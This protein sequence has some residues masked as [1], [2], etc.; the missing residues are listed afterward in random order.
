MK[1]K[2]NI[3]VLAGGIAMLVLFSAAAFLLFRGISQYSTA[4]RKAD[5]LFKRLEKYYT[6]N[7]FPTPANVEVVE[8]NAAKL[9][10]WDALLVREMRKGEVVADEKSPSRF[11]IR[12]SN[13]RNALLGEAPR[14]SVVVRPGF[15]FGFEQYLQDGAQL[16]P[17]EIVQDLTRQLAIVDVI[18]KVLFTNQIAQLDLVVRED[19]QAL[20]TANA[21]PAA[22]PAG[23]ADPQP[24]PPAS[25][26]RKFTF[27]I[28]F[29]ATE[30]AALSVLNGLACEKTFIVPTSVKFVR[31]LPDIKEK[32][33]EADR[34]RELAARSTRGEG[35][36]EVP[37]PAPKPVSAEVPTRDERVVSGL[38][39]EQPM[40]VRIEMDVYGLRG[41]A[42]GE[43]V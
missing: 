21:T 41:E 8:R 4:G 31:E 37:A 30:R 7:P 10:E 16:P 20:A 42:S 23:S 24:P 38:R 14:H 40:R 17:P 32:A 13:T 28:E 12:L 15:G 19:L 35:V 33:G 11:M 3:V 22:T 36:A 6:R 25:R 39:L 1:G 29:M 5:D 43:S 2:V 26:F 34:L 18:S 9:T 27:A